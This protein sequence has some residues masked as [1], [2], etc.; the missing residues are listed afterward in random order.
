MGSGDPEVRRRVRVLPS[1]YST[2]TGFPELHLHRRFCLCK[3]PWPP[4]EGRGGWQWRSLRPLVLPL[5]LRGAVLRPPCHG[6]AMSLGPFV[7]VIL[8]QV[9]HG[10]SRCRFPHFKA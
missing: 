5:F 1:A 10:M 4:P 3:R 8:K 7:G 2:L 6:C 9:R